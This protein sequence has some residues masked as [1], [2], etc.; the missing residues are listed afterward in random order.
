MSKGFINFVLKIKKLG[1]KVKIDTNGINYSII[2][3]LIEDD[4]IDFVALDFKAMSN[5]FEFI[6]QKDTFSDFDKTLKYLIH[7][8]ND[9]LIKLEIRTT[10]HTSL[11]N[12][13]DINEIILYLDSLDF[14]SNYFIQNFRD[15]GNKILCDLPIQ[16]NMLN[17]NKI[18]T[19]KNFK[20]GFRN[21]FD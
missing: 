17:T 11:L 6:T 19:P 18:I 1:Y 16:T 21:F 5:K 3:D 9:N 20:I 2:K 12:E 4:L 13:N 8:N 10:V 15:D 14:K 7:K